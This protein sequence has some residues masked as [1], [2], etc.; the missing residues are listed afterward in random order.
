MLEFWLRPYDGWTRRLRTACL[1]SPEPHSV[2]PT[3]LLEG[4]YGHSHPLWTYDTILFIVGGS[5]I[6][7]AAPYLLDH[8]TRKATRTKQI[9][10][11]WTDRSEAFIRSVASDR[12]ASS[13]ALPGVQARFFTTGAA[14]APEGSSEG[15]EKE[16]DDAGAE[17]EASAKATNADVHVASGRPDVAAAVVEAAREG[18]ESGYRVAVLVCGPAG[19][20]DS[21][22][23]AA[24]EARRRYGDTVDYIEEAFGW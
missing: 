15:S 13:L 22:R 21:A 4:P 7:A 14:T 17:K 3:I 9:T 19:M 8:A 23:A 18:S 24:Y 12:L 11:L 1:R 6:T 2:S 16:G 5:G 10:L 20:A